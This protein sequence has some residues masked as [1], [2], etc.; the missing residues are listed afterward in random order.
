MLLGSNWLHIKL[1]TLLK[2]PLLINI[3]HLWIVL[4][5]RLFWYNK[6]FYC[7]LIHG[8]GNHSERLLLIRQI[9]SAWRVLLLYLTRIKWLAMC[10]WHHVST[11]LNPWVIFLKANILIYVLLFGQKW[12]LVEWAVDM[13][14]WYR[15]IWLKLEGKGF[16]NLFLTCYHLLK[17]FKF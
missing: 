9:Y 16:Q 6:S 2:Y 4:K 3:L 12:P 17:L 13:D 10:W 1:R 8:L 14:I 5:L 15:L 11:K 7:F